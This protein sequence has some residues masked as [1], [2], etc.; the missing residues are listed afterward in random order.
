MKS[1]IESLLLLHSDF[2]ILTSFFDAI[3]FLT[4]R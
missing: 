2:Y 3:Y 1:Q 4:L